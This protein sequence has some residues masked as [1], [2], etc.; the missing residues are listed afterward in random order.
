[1][2]QAPIFHVNGDDPEA[3]VHAARLAI[4]FR[5]QFHVDVMLDL[6]CYRRHGHNETD[7]ATVTQPLMYEAICGH[8][9][10]A[11]IYARQLSE[12]GVIA[13]DEAKRMSAEDRQRLE[14]ALGAA[15]EHRPRQRISTLGGLWQG[16]TRA[17]SDWS[18]QTAVK[19]PVLLSVSQAAARVPPDFQVHPKLAKVLAAR[20][21]MAQGGRPVDWGCAEQWAIGSLL[22]EGTTVRLAGQDTQRGTFSHRHAVLHDAKTGAVYAPLSHLSEGQ[23]RFTI[24]NTML[25]EL[26]VLGFEY[27]FSSADPHNLVIWEA[28]FGDFANGAQPVIDQFLASAESKWQRMSGLVLLLPHG[29]E[30]QGPEHSSARLERFL[31]L[32]AENNLQI[33]CPTLPAQYFHA[34]RRQMRRSFRKP[35]VLLMPKSLLR[36]ERS[37]S[38][39]EEFSQGTFRLVLDDPA[40]PP[41]DS[42]RRL[43]MCSGKIF[44]A[45]AAA[46]DEHRLGDVAL[47]RIEQ[48]YPFPKPELQA[49]IARYRQARDVLWVQEEPR[50]M[51]AW[52]FVSPRLAELLPDGC[53]LACHAR[54]E[55]ASPATGSFRLHQIEEEALIQQALELSPRPAPVVQPAADGAKH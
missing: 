2:I 24:L 42:V 30:G 33:C 50:N 35:L 43:V 52:S 45:L 15:R 51:G 10:V 46:R 55:A 34:L 20:E 26:A 1:M 19:V 39:L 54:R 18:A 25:S 47:V 5:Q 27:G 38:S 31:Q 8:E 13:A 16:L 7:D 36:D 48:L 53:L 23:A 4:G 41:R 40:N 21:E 28:Q 9:P 44:F 14:E 29:Y 3:V 22:R 37:T 17:G 49:I 6:W 11:K 12:E 32:C